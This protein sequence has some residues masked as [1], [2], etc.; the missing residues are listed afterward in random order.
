LKRAGTP[1]P[2]KRIPYPRAGAAF[3]C[4]CRGNK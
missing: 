1:G 3:H 4:A 2:G